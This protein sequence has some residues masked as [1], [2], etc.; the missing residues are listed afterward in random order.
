MKLFN[1]QGLG[2]TLLLAAAIM[3]VLMGCGGEDNTVSN[4]T[5]QPATYT[6]QISIN[7]IG[8]GTVSRNPDKSAYN[9]GEQVTVRA[10]S[11]S[12]YRF[13]SWSG[14]STSTN[15]EVIVT[16]DANL[17]LTANF[18]QQSVDSL[19]HVHTWGDWVVTTPATCEADGV[20]T[21]TCKL[22]ANHKETRAISKLTGAACNTGGGSS[23]TVTLGGLKWM[24]KNLDVETVDSW[25]YG[26]GGE[27]YDGELKTLSSSEI[28]SNC[29]KYGRLYTWAAAKSACLL[30][31]M[32]LPTN[33]EW[34]ALVTAAGS[35]NTAGKKL[36]S[37]SGWYNN[38]NGTDDFQFSALP[39]GNRRSDGY[40]TEAGY[41]GGWWT[42]TEHSDGSAYYR[43][44]S[45]YNDNA[46]DGFNELS[47]GFSARCVQGVSDPG[48][49]PT[50]STYTI[51]FNANDGTVFPTSGTTGTNGK[52]TSLPTPI[53]SNYTFN[54]WFSATS[55]G[56]T[57]TTNTVFQENTTIYAQW[58][59]VSPNNC[60][61]DGTANSCKTVKIG[62]VTWMAENLNIETADSWC[63][64]N[65]PNSCAKYS[66][67]YTWAAAKSAC[68]SIGMRLPTNAEWDA[69]VTAA[70]GENTAGKKLKSK[71]G[72]YNNG[73]GTDDFQFSALP[74][75]LRNPSLGS[76]ITVVYYGYW[77][78]ATEVSND[79][80]YNRYM[81][82]EYDSVYEDPIDKSTAFSVRCIQD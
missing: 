36:K 56:S 68:Q 50:P 46:N 8:G 29:N 23:E 54:G 10:V 81:Y 3:A 4:E 2:R 44:M 60:G 61:K 28:Q 67:L 17:A 9:A 71:S 57:V 39:G 62:G 75:G 33:A 82:Y 14:V 7:P 22:D 41:N 30:V 49:I 19:S 47:H 66:R 20:E 15:A 31:G 21:R 26:E 1:R 16:M 5:Q 59:A 42:I 70:G 38:G 40:F 51:M 25:C 55:G 53:R 72:W 6:L 34:D 74:G 11:A 76:F 78:T 52:L 32:R 73:N 65:S 48:T 12:G 69:L 63:Y 45:Y 77:W 13:V 80:A 43:G 79:Y 24:K 37:K 35:R 58:T 64:G 18:Q 27:A